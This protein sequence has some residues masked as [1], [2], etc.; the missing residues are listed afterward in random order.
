M[1]TVT[2]AGR[3]G[4]KPEAKAVG[5]T[6][7]TNVS[8]ATTDYYGKADPKHTNWH[9]LVI[10]GPNATFLSRYLD[11]GAFLVVTGEIRY[12]QYVK[13][14][15]TK[16]ITEIKVKDLDAD[17]DIFEPCTWHNVTITT[18][19]RDV[20]DDEERATDGPDRLLQKT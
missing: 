8:L 9:N 6:F 20:K 7:V 15:V 1:N 10:W 11:K 14:G 4:Q 18:K 5:D 17:G 19:K 13:D 3:L 16:Y 2:L 12:R